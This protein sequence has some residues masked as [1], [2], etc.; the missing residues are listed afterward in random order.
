MR[1]SSWIRSVR[2]ASAPVHT[3]VLTDD[4]GQ[5]HLRN[6]LDDPRTA[7]AGDPGCLDGLRK[8]GI[9]GPGFRSD[10]AEPG[11]ECHGVDPHPLD[12]SGS[13]PLSGTDLGAFEGRAGRRRAGKEP[14]ATSKNDFRIGSHVDDECRDLCPMGGLGQDHGR[15]I[16]A[17]MASDAGKQP[18]A[19]LGMQG[20]PE[21]PCPKRNR[22]TDGEGKGRTSELHRVDAEKKMVHDRIAH[23]H[24]FHDRDAI[25]SG[26]PARLPDRG[27]KGLP[28]NRR[29]FLCAAFVHHRVRHP[30]HQVFAKPNL[31][32][33]DPGRGAYLAI[34]EARQVAGDCRRA[35]VDRETVQLLLAVSRPDIQ[36]ADRVLLREMLH[37]AGRLPAS[38]SKRL[39]QGGKKSVADPDPRDS[40]LLLE[41]AHQPLGVAGR[42]MHVRFGDGDEPES[43]RHIQYQRSVVRRLAHD[44]PMHLALR[45]HIDDDVG[46]RSGLA[47][48]APAVGEAPL[49]AVAFLNG[50]P[51]AQGCGRG[52]NP[53]L[54]KLS[55][56]RHNLASPAD[57]AAAAYG[58]EIDAERPGCLEQRRATR[59]P[60]PPP[61]RREY[62]QRIFHGHRSPVQ[63]ART[64][65]RRERRPA[66]AAASRAGSR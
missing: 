66:P 24:R 32:I 54:G 14:F 23:Q 55:E 39:L 48:E 61:G 11:L 58:V 63:E 10:H 31:R 26:L 29:H 30:R 40:P 65:R 50:I 9:I 2:S 42:M 34:P 1:P 43:G 60:S 53:V 38:L 13:G 6:G 59:K 44:L 35:H 21:A 37:N 3:P 51:F 5:A 18:G 28:H 7:Y 19:R 56:G 27:V 8:G 49:G 33:H 12:R 4:A 62:D 22:T 57:T 16:R 47:S 15:G 46:Q 45:R 20:E 52:A 36:H 41:R 25:Y 64:R 17:H